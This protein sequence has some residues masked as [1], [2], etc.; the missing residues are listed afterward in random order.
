MCGSCWCSGDKQVQ[1]RTRVKNQLQ[2]MALRQ[3]VQKKGKLWTAAGRAEFGST[4]RRDGWWDPCVPRKIQNHE[5]GSAT[6]KPFHETK[7][8]KVKTTSR[9]RRGVAQKGL[10]RAHVVRDGMTEF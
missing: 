2:A 7:W 9:P 8:R 1:A 6:S 3:G 4:Y 5:P 10:D